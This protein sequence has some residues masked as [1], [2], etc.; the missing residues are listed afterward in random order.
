MKKHSVRILLSL[1]VIILMAMASVVLYACSDDPANRKTITFR[2][3]MPDSIIY[4]QL[5]DVGPYLVLPENEVAVIAAEYVGG[6]RQDPR[7]GY[8]FYAQKI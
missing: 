7:G 5:F 1:A 3:T 4:N 2:D 8:D 6:D